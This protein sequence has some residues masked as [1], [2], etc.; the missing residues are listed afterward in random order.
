MKEWEKLTSVE[1][2]EL[3][4]RL[5]VR[6]GAVRDRCRIAFGLAPAGCGNS[7]GGSHARKNGGYIC[8]ARPA[9]CGIYRPGCSIRR[10]LVWHQ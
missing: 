5:Y 8:L 3:L 4:Q 10:L 2:G 6:P 7:A 9:Y 1:L